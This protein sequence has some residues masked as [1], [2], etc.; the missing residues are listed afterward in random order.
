MGQCRYLDWNIQCRE[1]SV[2]VIAPLSGTLQPLPKSTFESLLISDA[3][4]GG[5]E[6]KEARLAE[7][8]HGIKFGEFVFFFF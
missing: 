3:T 2:D 5:R 4:H 7:A 6:K 1:L 8:H